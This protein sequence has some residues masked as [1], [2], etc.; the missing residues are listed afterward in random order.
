MPT[1]LSNVLVTALGTKFMEHPEKPVTREELNKLMIHL[2]GHFASADFVQSVSMA[3]EDA[4]NRFQTG[5]NGAEHRVNG[6]WNVMNTIIRV[7]TTKGLILE[8]ELEK[9]GK[10]L[11]KEAKA[12]IESLRQNNKGTAKSALFTADGVPVQTATPEF[13]MDTALRV[14][15]QAKKN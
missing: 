1:K 6:M 9:A 7:F 15:S 13:P 3:A 12:Y 10:D 4:L 14:I 5:L 8:V 11:M 2:E